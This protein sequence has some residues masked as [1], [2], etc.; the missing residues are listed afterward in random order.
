VWWLPLLSVL[1]FAP[2]TTLIL[3]TLC[4]ALSGSESVWILFCY[5]DEK[6]QR[7]I[8]RVC[9]RKSI[10]HVRL[11]ANYI[12]ET[13]TA[14]T[15]R[16]AADVPIGRSLGESAAKRL[17]R[18]H[19]GYADGAMMELAADAES[20]HAAPASPGRRRLLRACSGTTSSIRR[21]LRRVLNEDLE[22]RLRWGVEA[23]PKMRDGGETHGRSCVR[24]LD[25][26][27]WAVSLG[28]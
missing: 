2:R 3:N 1:S 28:L 5:A 26:G 23:G 4:I 13:L 15:E 21:E 12:A 14:R 25:P 19:C 10:H 9:I 24:H 11:K 16:P 20:P 17:F 18:S 27:L 8:N 7:L 22:R 6:A